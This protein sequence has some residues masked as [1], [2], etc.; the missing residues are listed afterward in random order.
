MTPLSQ[1]TE[2]LVQVYLRATCL[3]IVP[4]L[5]VDDQ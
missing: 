4:V 3:R 1:T 2:N 5:P